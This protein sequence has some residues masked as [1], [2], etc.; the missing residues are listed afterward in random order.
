MYTIVLEDNNTLYASQTQ[1]IMQRSKLVDTLTILVPPTYEE[2]DM[3]MCTAVLEYVTA[4]NK[5][6]A[7]FLNL[8]EEL[9]KGY[10]QYS[11][12]V[13]TDLT[14]EA[15]DVKLQLTFTYVTLDERGRPVQQVR[16]TGSH[17]LTITPILAWSDIIPDEALCALDQRI[18]KMDAQMKALEEMISS[19]NPD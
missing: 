4:G 17:T 1:R 14:A 11:L 8:N 16:K 15:G 5:Y 19:Q 7:E 6:H 2:I 18:I 12:P 9:Y 13:D 3:T 10:L